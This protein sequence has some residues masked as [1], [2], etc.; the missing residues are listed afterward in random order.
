MIGYEGLVIQPLK[1]GEN[2]ERGPTVSALQIDELVPYRNHPFKLYEGDRLNKFANSIERNILIDPITVRRIEDDKFEILS[3]HNRVNA[4]K[5]LG[6]ET[7]SAII[8]KASDEEAEQL[9]IEANINQ[10]SFADW[11]FSQR[12]K[13]IRQHSNYLKEN[14]QQG[15]RNDLA[16][17]ATCVHS[18]HKSGELPKRPKSRDKISKQLGISSTVFVRYRKIA[19]LDEDVVNVLGEKLDNNELGFMS[20]YRISQLKQGEI[21]AVVDILK[22]NPAIK[23][24]GTN[25]KALY[26]KSKLSDVDLTEET[27]RELLLSDVTAS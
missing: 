17:D 2:R 6:R 5:Q 10:Q 26:D 1:K 27:T 3:G 24:K 21:A 23:I 20:A 19:E 4:F 15:M 25:V 13:V 16:D 8:I 18:E 7:I 11:N 22:D 12:I 9:V 14:S